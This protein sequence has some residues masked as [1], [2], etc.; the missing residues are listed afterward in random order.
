V[1]PRLYIRP[2]GRIA[3]PEA[4]GE[5]AIGLAVAAREDL[6]FAAAETIEREGGTVRRRIVSAE[7]LAQGANADLA[8]LL[9]RLRKPRP[10]IAGVALDRPRI[11]GIVNVT[12][13]S[14]SD[15][16]HW[17]DPAAAVAHGLL[18]E[19]EGADILDIGGE[20]TRPGAEPVP[21][22]EELRRVIPV[23]AA[24]AK[25]ARVPISVDT[26]NAEVMR[27]AADA[28]ARIINDVAAL[29]YD[30]NGLRVAAETG[31]PVVLMHALGDPRTMQ[32]D[33]RYDDVA[34]D[35]YDWLEARIAACE[36]AGIARE[37][38]IVDPG[39][40]FG[41]TLDHN[42]ALLGSLSLFHGLGCPILLGASRKSFIGKLSGAAAAQ[43]LPGSVA[44][45]LLGVVQG[46]QIVRVHDVGAT[47]QALMVWEAAQATTL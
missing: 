24:L 33:P 12:P 3:P 40:G 14:F 10:A 6:C 2:V 41:K 19:A 4:G 39:I 11:M 28:G 7:R 8:V 25:T 27:H 13:D 36:D 1:T 30:P 42:L 18:L 23:I 31:L 29:G 44:A 34:L 9:Q 26:R 32:L 21:I 47:R 38:L 22:G 43:R 35:V 17:L 46:V 15:G 37:R 45:A 16:G 5:P 20:S